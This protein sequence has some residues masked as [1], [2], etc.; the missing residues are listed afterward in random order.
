M[1]KRT[2]LPL[3]TTA[4]PHGSR[5]HMTCEYRC[6]NACDKPIPNQTD[7]PEFHEV[8]ARAIARR[9]VLKAA[10]T[11]AGALVVGGLTGSPAAAA[12]S[13]SAR[14]P[15][16]GGVGTADFTPVAPNVHDR[17]TVPQGYRSDVVI[18]WGDPVTRQA[19]PFDVNHQTPAAA[20]TQFGYNNDYVGVI[21]TGDRRALLVTNHEYTDEQLMFPTGRYDSATIKQIAIASH[22]MAVVEIVRGRRR[23][24]WTTVN[25]R[26]ARRNRRITGSS[27]FRLVGPAAGDSRLR[28]AEDPSGRTVL[29]TLGNCAGG[30]TPWGTVLS[31]EENF[32]GYFDTSG[33]LDARYTESYR[34]YGIAGSG[35]GWNEVDQRFDLAKEPHEP[36]RF[37][38]IVELDPTDPRSTPLKRTM[39]GRFKH[40]GANVTIADSGHAVVYMG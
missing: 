31:G 4:G 17:V 26:S 7:H 39:L 40:E 22:G 5:S 36:F 30:T 18:K 3:L 28:T 8:A 6:G 29:G 20:A 23:G 25:H 2:L 34:R 1:T 15:A 13:A 24:S 32:N 9:S 27:P 12:P 33:P 21:P 19:R 11:G 14:R 37:G 10:G 35:R 16:G 38:W